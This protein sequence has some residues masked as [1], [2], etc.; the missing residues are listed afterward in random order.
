MTGG[1]NLGIIFEQKNFYA[2]C[3]CIC[4]CLLFK[5]LM[6]LNIMIKVKDN[7]CAYYH[8]REKKKIWA[9]INALEKCFKI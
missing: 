8:S 9:Q 1:H 4:D 7:L 6:K 2:T 5:F 3:N